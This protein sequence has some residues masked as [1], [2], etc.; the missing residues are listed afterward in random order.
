MSVCLS[1]SLSL[2]LFLSRSLCVC[3]YVSLCV[4]VCVLVCV[5][6]FVCVW[7]LCV[8]NMPLRP[9]SI[10]FLSSLIFC[11]DRPFLRARLS[12]NSCKIIRDSMCLLALLSIMLL[13]LLPRHGKPTVCFTTNPVR[14]QAINAITLDMSRL[15]WTHTR[16]WDTSSGSLFPLCICSVKFLLLRP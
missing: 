14:G 6:V 3:V 5:C 9:S 13:L 10:R 1:V 15:I 12:V 8:L 16:F 7:R 11:S 2:S 4:C